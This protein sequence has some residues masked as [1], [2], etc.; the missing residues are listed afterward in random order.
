MINKPKHIPG[1]NTRENAN[2]NVNSN[3]NT[4]QADNLNNA[5]YI[6]DSQSS[7][8]GKS[9]PKQT[10]V[11][12]G[13]SNSFFNGIQE[14]QEQETKSNSSQDSGDSNNT[15]AMWDKHDKNFEESRYRSH[16]MDETFV[17][18]S[19]TV[20]RQMQN[21]GFWTFLEASEQILGSS[22]FW[23]PVFE[24]PIMGHFR[25]Q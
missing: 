8:G 20:A 25:P 5:I 23:D 1:N 24:T 4:I 11:R 13:F 10:Q 7:S 14:Q 15:V 18:P 2:A 3:A 12:P 22:K 17:Y 9:G 16:E 6:E 21:W 19:P